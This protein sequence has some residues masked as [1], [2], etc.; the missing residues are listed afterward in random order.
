MVVYALSSP[1]LVIRCSKCEILHRIHDF[2]LIIQH[3]THVDNFYNCKCLRGVG[4]VISYRCLAT[5]ADTL[6]VS[7]KY[8]ESF[9]QGI[10]YAILSN[11]LALAKV[12]RVI[13][14]HL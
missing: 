4:G 3:Q 14:G 1:S 10:Q 6:E 12:C 7:V 8:K 5:R 2:V 11:K 13:G 9:I